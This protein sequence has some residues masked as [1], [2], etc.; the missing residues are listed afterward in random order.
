MKSTKNLKQHDIDGDSECQGLRKNAPYPHSFAR[1]R[2]DTRTVQQ[3]PKVNLHRE[4]PKEDG[5]D[6]GMTSLEGQ[7]PPKIG[8]D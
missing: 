8:Y 6:K 2:A 7:D 1:G 3:A 4:I 5:N